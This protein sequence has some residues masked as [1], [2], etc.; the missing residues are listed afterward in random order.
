MMVSKLPLPPPCL[1][2]GEY[3]AG[4]NEA[5]LLH[6][7]AGLAAKRLLIVGLGKQAKLTVH[8]VRNAAG[9]AVRFI[10]PRG[11]RE[12]AL[13]L[14]ESR[15]AASARLRSR[16]RRGRVR[17]RLR[18]RHLSQRPHRPERAVNSPWPQPADADQSALKPPLPRA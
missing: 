4:A 3:K 1:A 5:L 17:G 7:P 14:P 16:R 12:L 8:R 11:I 10:K 6:A 13:A 2:S 9:T 18:P 15:S